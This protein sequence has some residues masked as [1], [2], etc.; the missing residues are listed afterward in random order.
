M[1]LSSAK[2]K[3]LLKN[4]IVVKLQQLEL[5]KNKP[6]ADFLSIINEISYYENLNQ[7]L[8]DDDIET[9][10]AILNNTDSNKNYIDFNKLVLSTPASEMAKEYLDLTKNMMKE[11]NAY[12]DEKFEEVKK[13]FYKGNEDLITTSSYKSLEEEPEIN[14]STKY[15]NNDINSCLSN[16]EDL[17][18]SSNPKTIEQFR[19]FC[20]SF[21][22]LT[23]K[24]GF[25]K[26]QQT[27][28]EYN[29]KITN[30]NIRNYIL[31]SKPVYE[32]AL[33]LEDNSHNKRETAITK[34]ATKS[35]YISNYYQ[36]LCYSYLEADKYCSYD[37]HPDAIFSK[38]QTFKNCY[39][40]LKD[41]ANYKFDKNFIP[42]TQG[43][44]KPSKDFEVAQANNDEPSLEQI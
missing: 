17:F 1:D 41:M 9:L 37:I 29:E 13:A 44:C 5:E 16:F 39:N 31:N 40:Y 2:D 32:I 20:I 36:S 33:T 26:L 11:N 25:L 24:L 30:M 14:N 22:E 15:L 19:E 18:K 10:T 4:C 35:G 43:S 38:M 8:K 6:N 28:D 12:S 34:I 27:Y 3:I 23:K 42:S 7:V 21:R